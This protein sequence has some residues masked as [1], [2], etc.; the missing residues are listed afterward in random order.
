MVLSY[1]IVMYRFELGTKVS[2][3][4]FRMNFGRFPRQEKSHQSL[5][6][7][8]GLGNLF[9]VKL[10]PCWL[11]T[12]Q[13]SYRIRLLLLLTYETKYIQTLFRV[14]IGRQ[15]ILTARASMHTHTSID[16]FCRY[17]LSSHHECENPCQLYNTK[18]WG[19]HSI[20]YFAASF[21][22]FK[23]LTTLWVSSEFFPTLILWS[24][25]MCS[26]LVKYQV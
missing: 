19:L 9:Q 1:S 20:I 14:N 6:C 10:E 25:S 3:A 15:A 13:D 17:E 22:A 24:Q 2:R 4:T 18:H 26:V 16:L 23:I 8:C 11:K 7:A 12:W 21:P 5:S